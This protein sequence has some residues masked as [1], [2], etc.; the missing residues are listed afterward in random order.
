VQA[1]NIPPVAAVPRPFDP[2]GQTQQPAP[3]QQAYKTVTTTTTYYSAQAAQSG[4]AGAGVS[5]PQPGPAIPQPKTAAV[6]KPGGTFVGADGGGKE[7]GSRLAA[8]QP[9]A[10]VDRPPLPVDVPRAQFARVGTPVA[11]KKLKAV[12]QAV[13][14]LAGPSRPAT[15]AVLSPEL[16][17]A[18][19]RHNEHRFV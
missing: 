18:L 12:A 8:S 16:Q 15:A 9:A 7:A 11:R 19:D 6:N 14:K 3:G 13:P 4:E 2:A 1:S 10:A 17:A 5:Q